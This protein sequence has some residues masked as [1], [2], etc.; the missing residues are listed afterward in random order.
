[1]VPAAVDAPILVEVD[2]VHKGLVAGVAD[3]AGGMPAAM[4][5][6]PG[7]KHPRVTFVHPL[8]AL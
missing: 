2:E 4:I 1:M 7:G 5:P 8:A 6:Q 3:E